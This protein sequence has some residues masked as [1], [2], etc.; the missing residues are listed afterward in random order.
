MIIGCIVSPLRCSSM[1]LKDDRSL[2]QNLTSM[3]SNRTIAILLL[4]PFFISGCSRQTKKEYWPD[5][6]LKSEIQ[7][8]GTI[9]D[10]RA[11]WWYKTGIKQME[12]FYK[13]NQL[14]STLTR[15][16]P[17]GNK[18]EEQQYKDNKP[19]GVNTTW[20]IEGNQMVQRY[21]YKGILNGT[22]KEWYPNRELKIQGQYKMGKIDGEW[23]FYDI[24][25]QILEIRNYSN[26][27]L[28]KR[29]GSQISK[30]P[31]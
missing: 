21:Y 8:K 30:K 15:W 17:N 22:I 27:K 14:D 11:T 16:F 26:G 6:K 29:I 7:V 24:N 2:P 20:Y 31:N 23:C 3:K 28:L 9:Y 25:G 18:Q 13:N 5:G 4:L 1:A 10:G 12:C 19:D